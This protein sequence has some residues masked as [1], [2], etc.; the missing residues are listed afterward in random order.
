MIIQFD[1]EGD[2]D[3]VDCAALFT[4]VGRRV[5]MQTI[6]KHCTPVAI[7]EKTGIQLYDSEAAQEVLRS[8]RPRNPHRRPSASR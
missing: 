6:R 7:D 1:E 5:A 3:L 2:R 4:L 8:V